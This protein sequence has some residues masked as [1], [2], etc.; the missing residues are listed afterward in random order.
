MELVD[1]YA[2]ILVGESE[3]S[4]LEVGQIIY[5]LF[6]KNILRA[7]A[8]VPSVAELSE[9]SFFILTKLICNLCGITIGW[10]YLEESVELFCIF[11]LGWE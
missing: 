4:F 1:E 8:K 11:C 6:V 7:F 2:K 9:P 10:N 3:L 5:T